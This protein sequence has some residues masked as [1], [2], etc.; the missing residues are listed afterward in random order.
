M[1]NKLT[2]LVFSPSEP[3]IG[4]L[5]EGLNKI[6]ELCE[7]EYN[8]N[9]FKWN[10]IYDEELY[11]KKPLIIQ[12]FIEMKKYLGINNMDDLKILNSLK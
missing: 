8:K 5:V 12:K 1:I 6:I 9:Q 2:Y 10:I 11:Y 3:S 4:K 7:I